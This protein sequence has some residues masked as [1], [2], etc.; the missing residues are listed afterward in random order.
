MFDNSKYKMFVCYHKDCPR[1]NN[2]VFASIQVGR[3][4][5][6]AQLTDTIGD[7]TG[8]NISARNRNW[9]ELT[10]LY[11]MWKN[12]KADYYG[13]FHYR[14]I[15][16]FRA[17]H[18]QFF[19]DFSED[20]QARFGWNTKNVAAACR[21]FDIITAPR[22]RVHP[23]G[24]SSKTLTNYEFYARDHHVRDID[25]A[26]A[27]IK[28]FSPKAYPYVAGYLFGTQCSFANLAVMRADLFNDYANWLF[29][30][31]MECERTTDVSSNDDYQRRI[32]GFVAERL[33]GGYV[34]FL[35]A[36]R[37]VRVGNLEVAQGVF[38]NS[39]PS[40]SEVYPNIVAQRTKTPKFV[41]PTEVRVAFAI[42]DGYAAHCGTALNSLLS[43][44]SPQQAI[45]VYVIHDSTLSED[46]MARLTSIAKH[47]KHVITFKVADS[48]D[49]EWMPQNREHATIV[50]YF[51][52][53]LHK[54]LPE[55]CDKV[56]Y[57]DSDVIVEDNI[58][59]LWDED[60]GEALIG[61][62]L[63]EGG[64]FQSRRL[65]LP[66]SHDYFNTGVCV[67]NLK[68]L[69]TIDIDDI[70]L[71]SCLQHFSDITLQD[72]DIINIAFTDKAKILPL[73]W[74]ANT[75]LYRWNDLEFRYT[76]SEAFYA[77]RNPAIIHFTDSR[78]PW[79]RGSTHPM[80]QLYWEWRSGTPWP[81]GVVERIAR[82][83]VDVAKRIERG[84]RLWRR[85]ARELLRTARV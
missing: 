34:D 26:L 4:S 61:A 24:L 80:K 45:T 33:C 70:F 56:I 49:F 27:V 3:A 12:V 21:K 35:A 9:D 15:L 60:I 55:N 18:K 72:Q 62:C 59:K 38:D 79:H 65:R 67:L 20:T 32:W 47:V 29:T 13:L 7:D 2:E 51:R 73:R 8:D 16:T 82:T 31:L 23:V 42:D 76:V 19:H 77:S 40:F 36:T 81:E 41:A 69:R 78:K 53:A 85:H 64:I 1:I 58:A 52:L 74:N 83:T 43:N 46:N 6:S 68:L 44:V 17:S 30:V 22:R 57:L 84:V 48:A 66:F 10:A 14:R 71:E 39:S 54:L 11:W 28:K 5:S 50:T 25:N 63:D 75:R 37:D